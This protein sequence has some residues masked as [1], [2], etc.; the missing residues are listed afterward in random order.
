MLALEAFNRQAG[1]KPMM[2]PSFEAKFSLPGKNR[3]FPGIWR[4][5]DTKGAVTIDF[6]AFKAES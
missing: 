1:R 3:S 6:L 2:K 4:W 5:L